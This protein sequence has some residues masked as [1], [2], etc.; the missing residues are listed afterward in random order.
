MV[1][2]FRRLALVRGV[3]RGFCW[4]AVAMVLVRALRLSFFSQWL[5]LGLNQ[6]GFQPRP[7]GSRVLRQRRRSPGPGAALQGR[8]HR[9][10]TG[11]DVASML[12]G[13]WAL[14]SAEKTY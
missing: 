8:S 2:G 14:Q 10:R 5:V 9:A 12:D 13:V 6:L 11:T 4:A 1:G 3:S 7:L